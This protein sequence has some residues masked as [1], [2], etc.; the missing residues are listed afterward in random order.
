MG[1]DLHYYINREHDMDKPDFILEYG[2]PERLTGNAFAYW[3]IKPAPEAAARGLRFIVTNFIVS[4]LLFNNHTIAATFPPVVFDSREQI[5]ELAKKTNTDIILMEEIEIPDD[6]FD[7]VGFFKEQIV[8]FNRVVTSYSMRYTDGLARPVTD[9][10]SLL[11]NSEMVHLQE[12]IRMTEEARAAY[13]SVRS[14]TRARDM[15]L[16]IRKIGNTLNTPSFKYDVENMLA[17]LGNPDERVEEITGLYF[18][19]FM[20]I[21]MEKYE[22]AEKL[23]KE[24]NRIS[25]NLGEKN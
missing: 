9:P 20:A 25:R 2:N 12:M 24:I 16:K 3:Q 8:S 11:E 7:F 5:L 17:L 6:N 23:K 21:Y 18:Q 13:L 10:A 15:V 14:R 19:K 1:P 4:P 22:L